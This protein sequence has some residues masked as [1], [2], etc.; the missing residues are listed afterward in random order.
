MINNKSVGPYGKEVKISD[1]DI[2][3]IVQL[4]FDGNKFSHSLI[5]TSIL[6][7]KLLENI[8][9]ATH[10]DNTFN[11]KLSTYIFDKIR[12]IKIEGVRNW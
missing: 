11:R 4:N 10:T 8:L 12:F 2:G 7:E 5:I 6:G 1:V 3:D 9:I